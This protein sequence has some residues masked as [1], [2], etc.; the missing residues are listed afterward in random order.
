MSKPDS[1]FIN[2]DEDYEVNYALRT[3]GKRETA[4]NRRIFREESDK[5]LKKRTKSYTRNS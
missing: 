4:E 2:R 3:N 1:P 5:K